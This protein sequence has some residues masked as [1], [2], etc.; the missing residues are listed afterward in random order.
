LGVLATASVIN[1][2]RINNGFN[3]IKNKLSFALSGTAGA[4][5]FFDLGSR[6]GSAALKQCGYAEGELVLHPAVIFLLT[7]VLIAALIA[8][9][10][11]IASLSCSI[12]CN[13]SE[14][15]A[16]FVLFGGSYLVIMFF[17]YAIQF[18]Y[19]KQ[20]QST[21]EFWQKA[22]ITSLFAILIFLL[23]IVLSGTL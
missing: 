10:G 8:A 22:A 4:F 7:L 6:Y 11:L 17:V 21:E 19:R 16:A 5:C 20:G 12:A 13:G 18:V 3:F 1:A 23:I 14:V 9:I 2:L 15:L